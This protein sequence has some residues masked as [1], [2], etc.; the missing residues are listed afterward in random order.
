[1]KR[2]KFDETIIKVVNGKQGL[3][4]SFKA[5]YNL[6]NTAVNYGIFGNSFID[7]QVQYGFFKRPH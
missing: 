4:Y 1:M 6:R 2:K 3:P 7:A 5:A